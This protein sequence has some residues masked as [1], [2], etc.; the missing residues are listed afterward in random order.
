MEILTYKLGY[1]KTNCY[2]IVGD[3]GKA[4]AIDIG[5]DE[6]FLL[7]EEIKRNFKIEAI[8]LTH[9][10][11]D[12]ISGVDYF[13][14]RGA[15]VYMSEKEKDFILDRELNLSDTYGE[16]V[17]PFKV[18]KFVRGG[19]IIS[20]FGLE[21]KVLETPGHTTG[22]VCYHCGESLFSGDTLFKE[23]YGRYD[24]KTGSLSDLKRSIKDLYE[25]TERTVVY[26]GH[27]DKTTIKD[28]KIFNPIN[29]V[30]D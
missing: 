4:V 9:G 1:M 15:K 19:D 7:L 28:E 24:F 25:L 2:V 20:L 17:K 8:L 5:G 14:K 12:H 23:S 27:G 29:Y 22:S 10:H 16:P 21:F 18:F 30:I 26:P 13:E 11:F 3:G 6:K